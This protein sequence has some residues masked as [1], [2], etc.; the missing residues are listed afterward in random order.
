MED[1][2][3]RN[4]VGEIGSSKIIDESTYFVIGP[5]IKQLMTF[6]ER[7]MSKRLSNEQ[8]SL[9]SS[10]PSDVVEKLSKTLCTCI[11]VLQ[12]INF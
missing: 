9:L 5:F 3:E 10:F 11:V 7:K 4:L 1:Y 8:S 6:K 12:E 2:L